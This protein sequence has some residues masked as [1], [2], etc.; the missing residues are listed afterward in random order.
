MLYCN[1]CQKEVIIYGV[2]YSS[3][4]EEELENLSKKF[5]SEGKIV[6][7]NPPFFGP[8]KCPICFSELVDN[9][10]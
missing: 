1:K 2:S 7:F 8:Y 4:V 5:E 3:G 6:L 10:E 9:G